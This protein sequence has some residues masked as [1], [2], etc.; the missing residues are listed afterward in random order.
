MN[1]PL[2]AD[3]RDPHKNVMCAHFPTNISRTQD[4]WIR[5]RLPIASPSKR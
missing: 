2:R 5:S 4:E 1:G 3:P